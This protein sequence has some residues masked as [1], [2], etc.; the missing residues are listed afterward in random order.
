MR[1]HPLDAPLFI[2]GVRK[3]LAPDIGYSDVRPQDR[4]RPYEEIPITNEVRIGLTDA[5]A[6]ELRGNGTYGGSHIAHN[7]T[8]DECRKLV[9]ITVQFLN[10]EARGTFTEDLEALGIEVKPYDTGRGEA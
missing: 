5:I 4:Q 6:D 9:K 8:A 2:R 3:Y 7:L 1:L 10:D